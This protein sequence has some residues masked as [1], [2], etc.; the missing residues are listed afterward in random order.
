MN[1]S[2][3]VVDIIANLSSNFAFLCSLGIEFVLGIELL[4]LGTDVLSV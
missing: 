3:Q 4:V 2:S 1:K